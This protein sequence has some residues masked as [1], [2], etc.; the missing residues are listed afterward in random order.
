M[1]R[2]AADR[3]RGVRYHIHCPPLFV[4]ALPTLSLCA[5]YTPPSLR[6]LPPSLSFLRVLPPSLHALPTPHPTSVRAACPPHRP[7][8]ESLRAAL[9]GYALLCVRPMRVC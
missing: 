7:F 2:A 1:R 4:R 8:S 9:S 6:V 5:C 3:P